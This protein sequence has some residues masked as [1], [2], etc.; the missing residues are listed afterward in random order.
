MSPLLVRYME[1]SGGGVGSDSDDD[2]DRLRDNSG[3][4]ICT[5]L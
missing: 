2:S 4:L 5:Q 3:R 1:E